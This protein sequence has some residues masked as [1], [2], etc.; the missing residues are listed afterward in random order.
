MDG[1]QAAASSAPFRG[2]TVVSQGFA[3]HISVVGKLRHLGLYPPASA[4]MGARLYDSLQLLLH[5]PRANTNFEWSSYTRADIT[6]AAKV[7][8]K[9]GVHVKAAVLHARA[10]RAPGE[11]IG[12]VGRST[13]WAADVAVYRGKGIPNV[14][15]CWKQLQSAEV[16]AQQADCCLLAVHGLGCTTNF[17][18]SQYSKLQLEEAG[19]YAVSKGVEAMRAK[20]NL[21]AVEQVCFPAVP[22]CRQ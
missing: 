5:G 19:Q 11:W 2:S 14:H 3:F 1:F 6:A 13:S 18:A 8:Q 7:L 10:T 16:A 21:E 17:P 12:V 9:K 4:E 22:C 15:V 20:A